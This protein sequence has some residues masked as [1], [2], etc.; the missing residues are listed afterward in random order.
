M[1]NSKQ[2]FMDKLSL[3]AKKAG[4]LPAHFTERQIEREGSIDKRQHSPKVSQGYRNGHD[5][6]SALQE[7]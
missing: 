2:T 6:T 7:L 3:S 5:M 4:L 1:F